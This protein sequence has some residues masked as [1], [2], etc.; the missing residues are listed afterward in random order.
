ME[1]RH[2]QICLKSGNHKN[3]VNSAFKWHFTRMN[4]RSLSHQGKK[5]KIL[6]C[7]EK[8]NAIKEKL[9]LWWR[10]VKRGNFSK[11]SSIEDIVD[12]SESSSLIPS[13]CEEIVAYLEMLSTSFDRYFDVGNMEIS[14][15]W[16]TNPCFFNLEKMSDDRGAQRRSCRT[17]LKDAFEM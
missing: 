15:E 3:S 7:Y 4:D 14:E 11:F 17:A 12:S 10:Q 6:N 8:I 2:C 16:I 9:S 1:E 5:I 13:V